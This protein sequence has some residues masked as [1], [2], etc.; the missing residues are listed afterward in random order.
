M[1]PLPRYFAIFCCAFHA[2]TLPLRHADYADADTPLLFSLRF[3]CHFQILLPLLIVSMPCHAVAAAAA[4]PPFFF[5]FQRHADALTLIF[6]LIRFS[7]LM[8]AATPF[9]LIDAMPCRCRFC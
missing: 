4:T 6:S 2:A 1:T 5:F 8:P 3:R 9:R 7:P